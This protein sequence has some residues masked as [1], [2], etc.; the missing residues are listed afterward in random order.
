MSTIASIIT[1]PG[2]AA[3]SIIKI[4]GEASW[5]IAEKLTEKN[6][7]HR[8]I[9]LAWIL[10]SNKARVDQVLILPFKSPSSYTG[11]DLIELHSHGGEW[12]TEKVLELTL[13]AGARL[14][15]PG[16][17]TE[18]AFLN[19]K[20]DLSQAEGIL[21]IIN[22][23][24]ASA[25]SNAL[26][27]YQGHLGSA[28]KSMRTELL[29]LMGEIT[30]SI[31]FPDEV[32]DYNREQYKEALN[33]HLQNI[34]QLLSSE[35]EGH[36][37]R[38]GYKVALIGNPNA[39]KSTLLNALLKK[40][41]AIVTEIAGTTRDVIEESFSIKGLPIVL[42]DT[43]GIRDSDDKVEQLG[44]E[45]TRSSIKEAD[46]V[47]L[48]IDNNSNDE[49]ETILK[50]LAINQKKYLLIANK[51]DL[52]ATTRRS[53]DLN[54]S[55]LNNDGVEELKD[56]IHKTILQELS[57]ESLIKINKRQADLLRKARASLE[58]SIQASEH[59]PE[60]FWTIDLKAAI[61]S[62]GEITGDSLTEELLDNIFSRFCI[63]K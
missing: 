11:E 6:F 2:N 50:Y 43:A 25:G 58:N 59:E 44:I 46:L 48:L 15:K 52:D 61:S 18:R 39:G 45:R 28:I 47:I 23:R 53:V 10:D 55:A 30:A 36:M 40:E 13:E 9:E 20:L 21:D 16:E 22:A 8:Y 29:N 33:K 56:L 32:G 35:K 51:K 41:R 26:K 17:F 27:I 60:D 3:V 57:S 19:H 24:T 38:H 14:A 7:K 42:L 1:A 62:L 5:S 34:D 37:L 31:D 49:I 54:I 12:V 63:G 4:S